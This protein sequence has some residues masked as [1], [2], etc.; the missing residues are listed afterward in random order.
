[1]ENANG[2]D[3]VDHA[4][5]AGAVGAW[6][7]REKSPTMTFLY[8]LAAASENA[9]SLQAFLSKQEVK[10]IEG[11]FDQRFGFVNSEFCRWGVRSRES[12]SD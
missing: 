3:L 6:L 4:H 9:L 8:I 7:F 11:Y 12:V 5:P 1:M 10:G 2:L